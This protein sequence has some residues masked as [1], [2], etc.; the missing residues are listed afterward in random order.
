MTQFKRQK[1][2]A[3]AAAANDNKSSKGDRSEQPP[4]V[5]INDGRDINTSV[6][7]I[8]LPLSQHSGQTKGETAIG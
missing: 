8:N 6:Q 1:T 3:V 5:I 7:V 2:K 4:Q